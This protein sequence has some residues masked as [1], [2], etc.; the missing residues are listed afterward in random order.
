MVR[1][2]GQRLRKVAYM[3]YINE[4]KEGMNVSEIYLCKVKNIFKTKA[5]KTYYSMLLQDKTGVI[6]FE[7]SAA[8]TMN[9]TGAG[10]VKKTYNG[11][12]LN[13]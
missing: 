10:T 13:K 9:I 8:P 6:E 2:S 7:T 5:G 3:R 11:N 4:L 1:L 12:I